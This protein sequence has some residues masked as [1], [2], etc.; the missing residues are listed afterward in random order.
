MISFIN[1]K[2]GDT[3]TDTKTVINEWTLLKNEIEKINTKKEEIQECKE[4]L[5]LISNSG[6]KNFTFNLQK[7]NINQVDNVLPDNF[8]QIW[9]IKR[10]LSFLKLVDSFE[11]IQNLTEIGMS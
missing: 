7:L 5:N 9:R 6:A 8:L 2:L 11:D 4:I 3:S 1:T 10:I